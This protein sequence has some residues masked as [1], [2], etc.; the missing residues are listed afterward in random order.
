[1]DHLNVMISMTLFNLKPILPMIR[2]LACN[3][4]NILLIKQKS[5]TV[6]FFVSFSFEN[7]ATTNFCCCLAQRIERS[8]QCDLDG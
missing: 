7:M 2:I 4:E 3:H 1:M 5:E 6:L 8:A